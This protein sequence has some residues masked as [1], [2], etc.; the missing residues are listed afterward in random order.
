MAD[1]EPDDGKHSYAPLIDAAN[2]PR[3]TVKFVSWAKYLNTSKLPIAKKGSWAKPFSGWTVQNAKGIPGWMLATLGAVGVGLSN[4]EAAASFPW[5][6][7]LPFPFNK[8]VAWSFGACSFLINF[9]INIEAFR[10]FSEDYTERDDLWADKDGKGSTLWYYAKLTAYFIVGILFGLSAYALSMA[11]GESTF[12][13]VMGV[14]VG[15]AT[16]IPECA[17]VLGDYYGVKFLFTRLRDDLYAIP[18]NIAQYFKEN[19]GSWKKFGKYV[20]SNL[21]PSFIAF[22]NVWGLNLLFALGLITLLLQAFN[23]VTAFV[24]GLSFAGF[25]GYI[26]EQPFYRKSISVFIGLVSNNWYWIKQ[27]K[28][29]FGA[30]LV[31]ALANG[32]VNGFACFVGLTGGNGFAALMAATIGFALPPVGLLVVAATIAV[33][34]GVVSFLVGTSFWVSWRA[35][36]Y[37]YATLSA[38]ALDPEGAEHGDPKGRLP[39]R[40]HELAHS[41]SFS[42]ATHGTANAHSSRGT[43]GK[44]QGGGAAAPGS[45]L[46]TP[47]TDTDSIPTMTTA[48]SAHNSAPVADAKVLST[49]VDSASFRTLPSP[50]ASLFARTSMGMFAKSTG[51]AASHIAPT[52]SSNGKL[53]QVMHNSA[54]GVFT[55]LPPLVVVETV[56]DGGM[57][58]E[59]TAT[60]ISAPS[61]SDAPEYGN[62]A[63]AAA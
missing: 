57:P 5:I 27:H 37:G 22:I 52:A 8:I 47:A 41:S 21:I 13:T 40:D 30:V 9:I 42:S 63:A 20:T 62:I 14:F 25:F 36:K 4:K 38:A 54:S 35:K 46:T 1:S 55:K 23:P 19:F 58:P 2:S 60:R 61:S 28:F 45:S 51:E 24:V 18:S 44:P 48:T 16:P 49:A 10:S 11:G 56:Q 29:E 3:N 17:A 59:K 33:F 12:A 7:S 43:G 6:E 34:I 53:T 32:T 50:Q 39:G 26:T 31:L 15:L